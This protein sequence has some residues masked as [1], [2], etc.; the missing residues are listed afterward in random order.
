VI[1]REEI[2][3]Y[4]DAHPEQYGVEEKYYLMSFFLKSSPSATVQLK[5]AHHDVMKEMLIQLRAGNK[6]DDVVKSI[7]NQGVT[8]QHLDLGLFKLD[9][10]APDIQNAIKG[11]KVG[12]YT[13]V[14]DTDQGLQIFYIKDVVQT[15]GKTLELATP[16]IESKLFKEIVDSKFSKWLDELRQRSHIQII[17]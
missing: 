5:S 7:L 3:A 8:V 2:K 9:A 1:T 4:Y 13:N 11:T 12:E 16:E 17:Q 6:P 14:I 10:L 15:A